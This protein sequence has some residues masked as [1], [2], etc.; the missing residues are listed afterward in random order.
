MIT[1]GPRIVHRAKLFLPWAGRWVLRAWFT[2]AIPSGK[3]TVQWGQTKLVG[4]IVAER[5]GEVEIGRAHV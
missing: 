4:S 1:I 3:V 5:S 2:G